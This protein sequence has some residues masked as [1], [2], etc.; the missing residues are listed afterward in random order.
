MLGDHAVVAAERGGVVGGPAEHLS[1]PGCDALGV[2]GRHVREERREQRILGH[3]PAVEDAGHLRQGLAAAGPREQ[4]R[5]ALGGMFGG[6][7]HGMAG[8]AA[9]IQY[10]ASEAVTPPE[11]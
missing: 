8:R 5:L 7:R 9:A 4:G 1:E 11:A 3:V 10:A 2:V 6:R